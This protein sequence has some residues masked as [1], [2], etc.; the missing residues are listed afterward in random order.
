MSFHPTEL[1]LQEIFTPGDAAE[2]AD[3]VRNAGK[4]RT[5]VYP[6]GGGTQMHYGMPP[7]RPGVGVSLEKM[8]RLVDYPVADLTVTV[9]AGMTFAALS[10]VL[11]KNRQRLP[12]DVPWPEKA[13][14]GGLTSVGGSG[15]RRFGYGSLRDYLLGFTA[16]DGQ[17]TVFSGGGR[18]VKNAAG[19]NLPRLMAGSLGTLGV[20]TQLTFWVRPVPERAGILACDVPDWA[21]GEK[22]LAD[23]L[24]SPVR[25]VAIDLLLGPARQ[26]APLLG[27]KAAGSAACLYVG[28]EGA[29]AE[30]PWMLETLRAEWSAAGVTAISSVADD[31]VAR[32]WH[33]QTEFQAQALIRVLPS[34]LV[35][36]LESVKNIV[37]A[38]SLI[39]H[40]GHGEVRLAAPVEAASCRFPTMFRAQLRPLVASLGGALTV[41]SCSADA[42]WSREDVWGPRGDAFAVMQALKDRFDP[43]NILNPARFVFEE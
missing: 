5:A 23:L 42:G 22:L 29:A 16:V 18:V 24:C 1:P 15:P 38:C 4:A 14:L 36:L 41:L 39:A 26:Q 2:V 43:E 32:F 19:Y 20:L 37:P 31:S 3:V 34:K 8:N 40:A 30:V 21:T 11:A 28:F 13:T 10:E 9:E 25:P 6:L 35:G 27:P 33:W 12:L 17:G 7:S